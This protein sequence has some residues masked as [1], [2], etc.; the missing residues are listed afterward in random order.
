MGSELLKKSKPGVGSFLAA[1]GAYVLKLNVAGSGDKA[2]RKYDKEKDLYLVGN[3][4]KTT[5]EKSQNKATEDEI[6]EK[7]G[8][9]EG[10]D[11]HVF[12]KYKDVSF[13]DD[14][15]NSKTV[16]VGKKHN[17]AT[18]SVAG[19][20][21]FWGASD[22]GSYSIR[23]NV[24]RCYELV[25]KKVYSAINKNSKRPIYILIKGHSRSGVAVSQIAVKLAHEFQNND[26]VN[27]NVMQRDPVPG[28]LH[29]G[30]D[31]EV[32]YEK[33]FGENSQAKALQKLTSTVVYSMNTEHNMFFT[34]QSVLNAN[35]I[36]LTKWTH[37]VGLDKSKGFSFGGLDLHG[38]SLMLLPKGVYI[39]TN[40]ASDDN[41]ELRR[42]SASDCDK[43]VRAIKKNGSWMQW[44]RTR[45]IVNAVKRKLGQE[46]KE[47]QDELNGLDDNRELTD[48]SDIEKAKTSPWNH[49]PYLNTNDNNSPETIMVNSNLN[50]LKRKLIYSR[51]VYQFGNVERRELL[52]AVQSYNRSHTIAYNRNIRLKKRFCGVLSRRLKEEIKDNG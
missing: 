25:R 7:Y 3:I 22:T 5:N 31:S 11:E 28:P 18:I 44:R 8:Q 38:S 21:G 6:A 47:Q 41:A 12:G 16:L 33:G 20:L 32:D 26:N 29:F 46:V 43:T 15:V 1:S 27:I 49:V 51:D 37:E 52:S 42:C 13:S 24:N 14:E 39:Q 9:K 48:E 19:P 40:D 4:W 2:W 10:R 45:V 35:R 23:N 17:K 50:K 36:V 34:P 30:V